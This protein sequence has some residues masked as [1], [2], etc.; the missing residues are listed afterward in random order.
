MLR[1]IDH[2]PT[3]ADKLVDELPFR[4][5]EVQHAIQ[6]EGVR[7]LDDLLRRRIPIALT[8]ERLGGG[9]MSRVASM[10]VEARGGAQ[11][12]IDEEVERY[13]AL[14]H[15]ETRRRPRA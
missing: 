14:T 13:C 5:V 8:D 3:L 1:A 12:D 9:V 6:F 2:N 4:W 11:R 7:H 10:L 15:T